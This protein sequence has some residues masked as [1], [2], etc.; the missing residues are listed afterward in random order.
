MVSIRD[1]AIEE[2]GSMLVAS[3]DK[4]YIKSNEKVDIAKG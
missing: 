1:T 3:Q 2:N 4:M